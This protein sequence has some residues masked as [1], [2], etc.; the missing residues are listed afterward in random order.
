MLKLARD[1]L[2]IV[3]ESV[4]PSPSFVEVTSIPPEETGRHCPSFPSHRA[5][6]PSAETQNLKMPD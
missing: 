5:T 6:S 4:Y 1:D 3:I 2:G